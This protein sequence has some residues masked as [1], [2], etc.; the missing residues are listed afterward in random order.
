VQNVT[1]GPLCLEKVSL[2]PSQFFNV[3]ALNEVD[4]EGRGKGEED[5]KESV[6]GR[7]NCIQPQDARQYLFCL[8]PRADIKVNYKLLKSVTHIGK[9]DIVWRTSMGDRGRLQT[10]QLQRMSPAQTDVRLTIVGVPSLVLLGRAFTITVRIVNYCERT[11]ELELKLLNIHQPRMT[12]SGSTA[13]KLGLLEA[14]RYVD[15]PILAVPHETGLQV[16][17]GVR[18]TDALSKRTYDFDDLCQVF[19][20]EDEELAKVIT[21]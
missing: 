14:S 16:I 3:N 17:S 13:A 12:W 2:D 19:V 8:T 4:D 11:L 1:L 15:V 20:C 7:V 5:Q 10:S 6:F 18:V 21:L 9:L